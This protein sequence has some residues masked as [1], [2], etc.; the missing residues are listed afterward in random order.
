MRK[1]WPALVY[2]GAA[3]VS[4]A[5]FAC[6]GGGGGSSDQPAQFVVQVRDQ[7]FIARIDDP[8][9]VE[10]ARRLL[11]GQQAHLILIG[12]VQ[13][14]SGGFNVDPRTGREWGWSL[15]PDSIT[16]SEVAVEVCDATPLYV[17]ENLAEWITVVKRYC[18]WNGDIVGE[19]D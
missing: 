9:Q 17:E 13:E 18:P 1:R 19:V 12:N 5:L 7:Q 3:V 11:S 14:G 16:F 8:A 15:A 4:F 10:V 6:G 2:S